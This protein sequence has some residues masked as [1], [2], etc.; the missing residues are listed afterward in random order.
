M[1]LAACVDDIARVGGGS[2][3]ARFDAVIRVERSA[4]RFVEVDNVSCE[5]GN[6]VVEFA[7]S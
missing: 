6:A 1:L 4:E 5:S 3:I 2:H 7:E